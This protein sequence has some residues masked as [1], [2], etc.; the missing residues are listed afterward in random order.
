MALL[1]RRA[2]AL[3]EAEFGPSSRGEGEVQT[4]LD[5]LQ[6]LEDTARLS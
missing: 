6:E 2:E 4:I 1:L 5:T 3:E